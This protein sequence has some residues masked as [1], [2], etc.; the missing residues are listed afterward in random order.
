[1]WDTVH[2]TKNETEKRTHNGWQKERLESMPPIG[3]WPTHSHWV[4]DVII[5]SGQSAQSHNTWYQKA[6]R[7][8]NMTLKR[9]LFRPKRFFEPS[10]FSFLRQNGS[11]R[12]SLLREA[13]PLSPHRELSPQQLASPKTQ[14]IDSFTCSRTQSSKK[15]ATKMGQKSCYLVNLWRKKWVS[16]FSFYKKTTWQRKTLQIFSVGRIERRC[17]VYGSL[18]KG[19]M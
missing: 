4:A 7:G 3:L 8:A 10:S 18:S 11:N 14:M 12:A 1:M 13:T 9:L 5:G 19:L 15:D 16:G 17:Y 2:E 6:K